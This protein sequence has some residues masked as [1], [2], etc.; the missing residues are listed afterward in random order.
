[1]ALI[2]R[3]ATLNINGIQSQT[4]MAMLA[5]FVRKQDIDVILLQ[6]MS[7]IIPVQFGGYVIHH[8]IGT[9]GRGTSILT[10]T[11]LELRGIL[12]L[13]SGRGMAG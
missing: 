13:P 12:R 4:K 8:N 9:S 7:T 2:Y 1:M 11:Q 5:D 3:I 6:E 10:R